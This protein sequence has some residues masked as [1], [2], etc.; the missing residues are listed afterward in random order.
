ML[1]EVRSHLLDPKNT[2][3]EAV[4]DSG[5]PGLPV[6]YHTLSCRGGRVSDFGDLKLE[7]FSR[8][9]V[10]KR[11][12]FDFPSLGR[13]SGIKWWQLA[14]GLQQFRGPAQDKIRHFEDL[15]QC[16]WS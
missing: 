1:A 6:L 10:R 11:I 15:A 3:D 5:N 12:D 14:R 8:K 4:S 13:I 9:T 16:D 7:I 2:G